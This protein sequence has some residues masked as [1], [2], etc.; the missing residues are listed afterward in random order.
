MCAFW[1]KM[2]GG[3]KRSTPLCC[4]Q[5]Y[6]SSGGEKPLCCKDSTWESHCYPKRYTGAGL[7]K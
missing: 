7:M 5:R 1:S 3:K 2:W 6:I 4:Y